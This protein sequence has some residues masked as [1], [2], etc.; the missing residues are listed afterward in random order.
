MFILINRFFY[1]LFIALLGSTLVWLTNHVKDLDDWNFI[2]V[3]G[4]II[5]IL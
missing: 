4:M 5:C 3:K 1:L 2:N